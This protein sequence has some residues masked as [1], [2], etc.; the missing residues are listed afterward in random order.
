VFGRSELQK[1]VEILREGGLVA[2]PTETVYG[3]GADASNPG[4]LEKIFAAKE[5]PVDHPLIVH[6]HSMQ[7][8]PL[9]ADDI[10]EKA[11]RLAEAFWPGPMTLIFRKKP[12]VLDLVTGYQQTVGLRIPS[13]PVAKALLEAFDGG[14]AAPSANRFGRISPT[15]ALAV[16]E[17][18]GEKVGCILEGGQCEVGVESTIIDVSGAQPVILRPGMITQVDVENVLQEKILRKDSLAVNSPRVSGSHESHYAPQTPAV[19]VE[20]EKI[21][22]VLAA[23]AAEDLP[24]VVLAQRRPEGLSSEIQFIAMPLDAKG[25]AHDLY[26]T[27]RACDQKNF[28]RIIIAAVPEEENW[29]AVRD[30]LMRATVR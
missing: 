15:T 7:Q 20:V 4:A 22:G 16:R 2:F 14:I 8:L 13:H 18:L 1:A 24:V 5:R 27:L 23:L 25:Y 11:M 17:E 19:L 29:S 21:A 6:L 12:H 10:S 9:W 28:R 3:L 26:A 30:R